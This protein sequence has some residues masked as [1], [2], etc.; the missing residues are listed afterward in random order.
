MLDFNHP[1][2]EWSYTSRLQSVYGLQGGCEMPLAENTRLNF[3]TNLSWQKS[4]AGAINQQ[5][6][7]DS[8]SLT[9]SLGVGVR[10]DDML[11]PSA[12]L[13]FKKHHLTGCYDLNA[14]GTDAKHY[15]RR[16]YVISYK[17][18]F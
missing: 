13:R 6:Y 16:S 17:L 12:G 3:F 2:T 8:S 1:Y 11:V 4:I 14:P 9:A 10:S 5:F 18:D 15:Y 7:N